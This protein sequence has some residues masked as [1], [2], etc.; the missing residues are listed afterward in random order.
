MA[1]VVK[2]CSY[3]LVHVPSFVRYGSKP[4][5][6]IE[7]NGGPGGTLEKDIYAHVR[8]FAEIFIRKA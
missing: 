8:S 7:I 6:D 2:E 3:V 1:V 4:I 5:R